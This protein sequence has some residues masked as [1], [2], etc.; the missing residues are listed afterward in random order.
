MYSNSSM[1]F[2][3]IDVLWY[4]KKIYRAFLKPLGAIPSLSWCNYL[5]TNRANLTTLASFGLYA[6]RFGIILAVEGSRA[7]VQ[8][9]KSLKVSITIIII[10]NITNITIIITIILI[11]IIIFILS[12]SS[13]YQGSAMC[14]WPK[15][16]R[17]HH[18]PARRCISQ[19]PD[20][21]DHDHDI[22]VDDHDHDDIEDDHD[23][24]EVDDHGH[25]DIEFDD[26]MRRMERGTT[27][28]VILAT[29]RS[30]PARLT[31][32]S[33]FTYLEMFESQDRRSFTKKRWQVSQS[34]W[35]SQA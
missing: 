16:D 24:I 2:E 7:W 21:H 8:G 1:Y 15:A 13:P 6:G 5:L 35:N 26:H 12:P 32:A 29:T 28:C 11:I 17:R 14:E 20:H 22:E 25:D 10:T 3:D 34:E 23:D 19:S 9:A 27:S 18:C 31:R 33:F 4:L 30:V